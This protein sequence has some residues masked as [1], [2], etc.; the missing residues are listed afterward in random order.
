MDKGRKVSTRKKSLLWFGVLF[1]LG[2]IVWLLVAL[3][4]PSWLWHPLGGCTGT[5]VQ[6]RDCLGYNSWSGI[7]SDVAE[8]CIVT[9]LLTALYHTWRHLNCAEPSCPKIG[10]YKTADGL[11]RYCG[12]HHPDKPHPQTTTE[13]HAR[14][15]TMTKARDSHE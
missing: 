5:K 3:V 7:F 10:K 13:I 15:H 6:V 1:L 8:Y 14:H 11:H 9:S 12:P 4:L 2:L